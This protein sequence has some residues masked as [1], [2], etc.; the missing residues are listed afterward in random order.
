MQLVSLRVYQVFLGLVSVLYTLISLMSLSGLLIGTVSVYAAANSNSQVPSKVTLL[1]GLIATVP[2][3]CVSAI[4][5]SWSLFLYRRY[6]LALLPLLL[7]FVSFGL[8]AL[9]AGKEISGVMGW[10]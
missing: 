4:A 2:I 9:V 10:R 3:A 1:L 5:G 6:L 7:P 8:I